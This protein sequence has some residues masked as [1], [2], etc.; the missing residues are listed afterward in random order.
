[1]KEATHKLAA[2]ADCRDGIAA[3]SHGDAVTVTRTAGR[4]HFLDAQNRLLGT[5]TA[6]HELA[7]RLDADECILNAG[8]WTVRHAD[9][10]PPYGMITVRVAT[11]QEGEV[12]IPWTGPEK[13]EPRAYPVGIVGEASYQPAIERC[14]KGEVSTLYR[15]TGN[16]HDARAIVVKSFT[17]AT[18]GYIPRSSWLHE[19]VHERGT[20]A[21]ATIMSLHTGPPTAVVLEVKVSPNALAEIGYRQSALPT[22]PIPSRGWLARLLGR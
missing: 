1:M 19:V 12:Y 15:E 16:P 21:T 11:G 5:L 6:R 9:E 8:A 18:I 3:A 10:R 14:H 4:L 17:G 13:R 7:R 20:G 22:A 2:T